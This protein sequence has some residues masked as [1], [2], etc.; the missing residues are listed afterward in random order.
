LRPFNR[1]RPLGCLRYLLWTS[2]RCSAAVKIR[3]HGG[4]G[5]PYRAQDFIWPFTW[6]SA[7]LTRSDPGCHILGLQP[8]GIQ[9]PDATKGAR[10]A[11][12]L[13]SPKPLSPLPCRNS[14]HLLQGGSF[15]KKR[16]DERDKRDEN[17]L[18]HNPRRQ[19][20]A[21]GVSWKGGVGAWDWR[22]IAFFYFSLDRG[23]QGRAV[24]K[25]HHAKRPLM[26]RAL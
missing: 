8:V 11:V 19:Q 3:V 16:K 5:R 9:R 22:T 20:L 21:Q 15:F 7:R 25:E 14:P 12:R 24:C 1:H 18:R 17:N 26:F 10:T 2:H 23:R 6:A 13:R 4:L